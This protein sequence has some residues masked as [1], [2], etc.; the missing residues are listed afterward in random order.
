MPETEGNIEVYM[1][2]PETT[3]VHLMIQMAT[4]WLKRASS[5][6]TVDTPSKGIT[7]A[8]NQMTQGIIKLLRMTENLKLKNWLFMKHFI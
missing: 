7:Q 2:A 3:I 5:I 4:K 8:Q 6:Y 1:L